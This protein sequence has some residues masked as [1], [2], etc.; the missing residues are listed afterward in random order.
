M[1]GLIVVAGVAR[2]GFD[3]AMRWFW[4]WSG[5]GSGFRVVGGGFGFGFWC[6]GA[7][8][9]TIGCCWC[10]YCWCRWKID[11]FNWMDCKTKNEI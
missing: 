10:Y 9:L 2:F 11:Y 5:H 8:G 4:F 3:L 7:V 1:A 6:F